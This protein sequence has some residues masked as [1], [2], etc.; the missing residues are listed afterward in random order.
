MRKN[1]L[2]P[3]IVEVEEGK[4]E[5]YILASGPDNNG[6]GVV[7]DRYDLGNKK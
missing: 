7:E 5:S 6:E 3:E 2:V 4:K 1:L